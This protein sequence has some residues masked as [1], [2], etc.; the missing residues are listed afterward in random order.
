M[1]EILRKACDVLG[2]MLYVE[3]VKKK[4]IRTVWIFHVDAW[5]FSSRIISKMTKL[6]NILQCQ[7]LVTEFSPLIMTSVYGVLEVFDVCHGL[8]GC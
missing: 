4:N 7:R 2:H 8:E 6:L 3:T 1:I 5:F